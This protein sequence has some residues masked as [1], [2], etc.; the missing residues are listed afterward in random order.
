MSMLT[1]YRVAKDEEFGQVGLAIQLDD[2]S[3]PLWVWASS[4]E[5]A[6]SEIPTA[7]AYRSY[8]CAHA[9]SKWSVLSD[10]MRLEAA[11]AVSN[12]ERLRIL[13]DLIEAADAVVMYWERRG[14]PVPT[15][16]EAFAKWVE[17]G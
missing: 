5:S 16:A 12:F 8:E 15:R 11:G 9:M 13:C 2:G 4:A 10:L 17:E 1:N 14:K 7:S 6:A 3:G